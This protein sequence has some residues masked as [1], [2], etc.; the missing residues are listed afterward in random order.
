MRTRRIIMPCSSE[1]TFRLNG[2]SS[3]PRYS[4]HH[5]S[6]DE[7]LYVFEAPIDMLS[8]IGSRE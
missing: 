7:S 3:D 8:Y 2:E 6:I 4:F 5:T 1:L